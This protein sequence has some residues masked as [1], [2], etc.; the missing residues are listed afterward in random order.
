MIYF[1]FQINSI[2][3]MKCFAIRYTV[4]VCFMIKCELPS[5]SFSILIMKQATE[6]SITMFHGK[7]S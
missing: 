3:T 7:D 1:T 4:P 5:V 6:S 2:L